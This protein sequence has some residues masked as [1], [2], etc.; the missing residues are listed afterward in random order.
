MMVGWHFER[1]LAC[2]DC[3]TLVPTAPG[4]Q[5]RAGEVESGTTFDEFAIEHRSHDLIELQRTDTEPVSEGALWDPMVRVHIELTDG[6]R[7]YVA[8]ASRPSIEE[9]RVYSFRPSCLRT[10]AREVNIADTDVR[11]GLD[12]KF[13]P[14]AVRPT[15]ID[16]F[17]DALHEAIRDLAAEDLEIAFVD[18]DDPHVS[19]APMPEQAVQRVLV[20]S[21]KIFDPWE[22]PLVE[23]FLQ[24]NRQETGV[25]AL[26]VRRNA[27]VD[28]D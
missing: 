11:R 13:F 4:S 10:I 26:R 25:L 19:I 15:K 23:R 27:V 21:S 1:F 18:A 3:G 14:H 16:D 8:T 28:D 22:F 6:D 7:L 5:S 9:E 24:E 17:L 20:A 2:C 12:L